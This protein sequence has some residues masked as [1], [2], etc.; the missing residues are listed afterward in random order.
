MDKN[1]I[2]EAL[3]PEKF[4]LWLKS[5]FTEA[6]ISSVEFLNDDKKIEK[7]AQNAYKRIPLFP[8]RTII[9]SIIGQKGFTRLIFKVRDKMLEA[10]SMDFSFFNNDYLRSILSSVKD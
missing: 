7:A 10:K 4:K 6:G 5:A 3:Q 9:K 1:K 2:F 8:Y